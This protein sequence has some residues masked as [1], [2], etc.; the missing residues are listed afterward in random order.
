MDN[1]IHQGDADLDFGLDGGGGVMSI[2]VSECACRV[3]YAVPFGPFAIISQQVP[4]CDHYSYHYILIYSYAT[5]FPLPTLFSIHLSYLRGRSKR[6]NGSKKVSALH[7][8]V[9][10]LIKDGS[11]F[12]LLMNNISEQMS[13]CLI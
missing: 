7:V 3:R 2:D 9:L 1:M 8:A 6:R 4:D 12:Y 11:L 5:P 13:C 10:K